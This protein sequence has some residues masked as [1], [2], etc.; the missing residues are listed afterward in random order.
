[1]SEREYPCLSIRQPWVWAIFFAGKTT[2]N[3][4][5]STR[6]RGRILVHASA[7]MTRDEYEDFIDTAHAVSRS[8]PFPSGLTLP[9]FDDLP[10]GCLFG[11]VTI[12]DC[13]EDHPSPWFF[14]RYG[15]VLSD[16][17]PLAKPIPYKGR[18]GFFAVP[19]AALPSTPSP[20]GADNAE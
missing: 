13:V 2:E 17:K 6:L 16:P 20:S 10:R 7:G 8:H 3:R 19:E 9:A 4:G 12:T 1:M 14:G 18:L 11:G 15:F 5:W